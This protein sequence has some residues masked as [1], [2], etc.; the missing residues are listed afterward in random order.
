MKAAVEMPTG[1]QLVH[2]QFGGDN[3]AVSKPRSTSETMPSTPNMGRPAGV[4]VSTDR[5]SWGFSSR[6]PPSAHRHH[7]A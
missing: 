2:P 4:V 1:R 5:A 3:P 6:V 7:N